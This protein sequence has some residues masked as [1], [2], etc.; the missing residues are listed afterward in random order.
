MRS[1]IK[2]FHKKTIKRLHTNND[3]FLKDVYSLEKGRF[4]FE[5][6]DIVAIYISLKDGSK[7]V[8]VLIK[9]KIYDYN[10]YGERQF[11][12][13]VHIK[14]ENNLF[15]PENLIHRNEDL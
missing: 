6:S 5:V 14:I 1:T 7:Q 15:N 13:P 11:C 9:T 4:L 12:A 8:R 10:Q 3:I 2:K